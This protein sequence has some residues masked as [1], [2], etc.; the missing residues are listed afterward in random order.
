MKLSEANSLK[1]GDLIKKNGEEIYL[2]VFDVLEED[3]QGLYYVRY[4]E[5]W[6]TKLIPLHTVLEKYHLAILGDGERAH[7]KS[8][9]ERLFRYSN[10]A[11]KYFDK[12]KQEEEK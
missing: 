8:R 11:V 10:V 3:V 12:Q 6:R 5:Q 2:F 4:H 9:V 1:V 7:L